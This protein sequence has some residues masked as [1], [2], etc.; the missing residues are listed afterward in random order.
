MKCFIV[1]GFN[2]NLSEGVIDEWCLSEGFLMFNNFNILLN[3]FC[4]ICMKYFFI[5]WRF[6]REF[7]L[8]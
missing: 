5:L 2:N 8:Y 1:F 4:L 6:N 7:Y 3:G